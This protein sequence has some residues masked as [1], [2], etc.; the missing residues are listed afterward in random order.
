MRLEPFGHRAL[1]PSKIAVASQVSLPSP[2]P[3]L[4][5]SARRF[6]QGVLCQNHA[7]HLFH[8]QTPPPASLP[9]AKPS[10]GLLQPDSTST[11]SSLPVFLTT[12]LV[13]SLCLRH[14]VTSQ[15]S[16]CWDKTPQHAQ[17]EKAQGYFGSWFQSSVKWLQG[18]NSMVEGLV[19]E[20]CSPQGSQQAERKERSQG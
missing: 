2:N 13:E 7:L 18:R 8:H 11:P 9:S 5:R 3:P 6:T 1:P 15:L 16:H 12:A 20:I 10:Q 17:F 14:C 4:P 19:G